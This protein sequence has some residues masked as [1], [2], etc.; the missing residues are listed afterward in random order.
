MGGT[1][2]NGIDFIRF[3][4]RNYCHFLLTFSGVYIQKNVFNKILFIV[5][6]IK[7][8]SLSRL[9]LVCCISNKIMVQIG[10]YF[11]LIISTY[12]LLLNKYN[13]FLKNGQSFSGQWIFME[14]TQRARAAQKRVLSLIPL[15]S[16]CYGNDRPDRREIKRRSNGFSYFTRHDGVTLQTSLQSA[17]IKFLCRNV[18]DNPY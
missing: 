9:K 3:S 15:L 11:Y 17:T 10:T 5:R 2:V 6:L 16:L 12:N 13:Y 8:K 18:H 1:F 14:D 4:F 7:T